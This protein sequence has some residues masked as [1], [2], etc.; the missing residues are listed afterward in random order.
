MELF[1]HMKSKEHTKSNLASF[2][3]YEAAYQ[4]FWEDW[5]PD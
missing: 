4:H 3:A 1:E 2:F 5:E